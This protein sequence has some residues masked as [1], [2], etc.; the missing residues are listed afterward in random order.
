L[1]GSG[2]P[3]AEFLVS[4]ELG[5]FHELG[6]IGGPQAS[7]GCAAGY[8]V[9]F[10]PHGQIALIPAAELAV[11]EHRG[12]PGDVDRAYGILAAYVARHALAVAGPIREYYLVGQH[13]T[14]DTA[15]WRTEIGWPIFQ[16]SSA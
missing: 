7:D 3:G 6:A 4:P 5:A 16:T 2:D 11:I 8:G 14:P 1:V 10:A 9:G 13:D 15:Q 12:S